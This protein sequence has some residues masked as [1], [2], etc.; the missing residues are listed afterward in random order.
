MSDSKNLAKIT[1]L[2]KI[3]NDSAYKVA[4]NPKHDGYQ[5]GLA[6]MVYKFF[7]KKTGLGASINEELAQKLHKPVIQNFKKRKVCVSR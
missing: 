2:D 1:V 4:I 5:R 7:D 3:L 6:S